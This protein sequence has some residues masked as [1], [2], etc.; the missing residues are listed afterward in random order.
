[1]SF[2]DI[3]D[4]DLSICNSSKKKEEQFTEDI[5][6]DEIAI[7]LNEKNIANVL[8]APLEIDLDDA[9]DVAS[10]IDDDEEG[11]DLLDILL[12]DEDDLS[13]RDE[14][15]SVVVF[16]KKNASKGEYVQVKITECT[17]STLIGE[18]VEP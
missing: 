10:S 16:P 2:N 1:M 12:D 18:I 4:I 3:K 6:P 7:D 17:S 11:N 13:G 5:V 15:N 14:R 9:I 8:N